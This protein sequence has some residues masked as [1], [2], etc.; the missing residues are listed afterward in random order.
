MV[1]IYPASLYFVSAFVWLRF[2]Y[3]EAFPMRPEV[4]VRLVT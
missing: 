4:D 1:T 2:F 3:F